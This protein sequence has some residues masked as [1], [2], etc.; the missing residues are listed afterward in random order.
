MASSSSTAQFFQVYSPDEL[1][2][3]ELITKIEEDLAGAVK[4]WKGTLKELVFVYNVRRG[5]P[6]IFPRF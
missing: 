6:R 3:A 5:L 1:T 2:Q 4:H